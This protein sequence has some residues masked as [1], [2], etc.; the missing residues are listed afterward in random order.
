MSDMIRCVKDPVNRMAENFDRKVASG[1][2]VNCL[3]DDK[4]AALWRGQ[5]ESRRT[6]TE[7]IIM[8]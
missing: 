5:E 2:F 1:E 6:G 7:G 4:R 3:P 8:V